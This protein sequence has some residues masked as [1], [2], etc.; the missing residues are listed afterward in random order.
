MK[1][2]I[3]GPTLGLRSPDGTL[4][5]IQHV[6]T[7]MVKWNYCSKR[8]V[9]AKLSAWNSVYFSLRYYPC[10]RHSLRSNQTST[11]IILPGIKNHYQKSAANSDKR[12]SLTPASLTIPQVNLEAFATVL[13]SRTNHDNTFFEGRPPPHRNP[14][15]HFEN[16]LNKIYRMILR[17]IN[18]PIFFTAVCKTLGRFSNFECAW[19]RN[20]IEHRQ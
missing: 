6:E 19:H 1:S 12:Q 18:E 11:L 16:S 2:N 3:N 14:L 4:K 7:S 13:Q 9:W 10:I 17:L 20:Y 8:A 15:W 5:D